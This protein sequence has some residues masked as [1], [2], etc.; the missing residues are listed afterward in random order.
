MHCS[1]LI[2]LIH[3]LMVFGIPW[4]NMSEPEPRYSCPEADVRFD[5]HNIDELH[6]VANWQNCGA[7]CSLNTLCLYWTW[8]SYD[9]RCLLKNS[10]A[11]LKK[12]PGA[13]SGE[14]GCL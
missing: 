9:N 13:Y 6:H 4:S 8:G 5:G 7:A 10:D 2:I 11:G 1:I 14:R 3:G 12:S